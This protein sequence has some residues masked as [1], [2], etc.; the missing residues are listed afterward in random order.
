MIARQC[1]H[2]RRDVNPDATNYFRCKGEEVMAVTTTEVQHHIRGPD[3]SQV[4]HKR[5]AVFE[6]PLRVTMLLGG[7]C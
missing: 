1:D 6:Q 2:G 7:P 4:S 3:S 5:E